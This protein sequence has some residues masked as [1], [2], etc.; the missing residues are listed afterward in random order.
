MSGS[1]SRILSRIGFYI[2]LAII[3]VYL[4]FPFY[5]VIRSAIV[6]NSVQ[7]TTPVVYWPDDPTWD[8]F[9]TVLTD[10]R[11]L[12]SLLNSAIVAGTVTLL[13]LAIGASS[14]YALGR[15][16]FR[17]RT[18]VLY[19]VLAMTMFPAVSV[20]GGLFTLVNEFHMYNSLRALVYSYLIFTLPFTVWVLTSF[21]R[22]MPKDLEEAAYVDGAT[23]F[24]TF[25]KVLLPLSAPGLVTTGLLAF[26]AAW[27]EFLYA[28][29]FLQTP[30][31]YTITLAIFNFS[32]QTGGGFEIPWGP[33]MAATV[34]V[35]IPL[36]VLTLIFQR[37]IIQGLTAG[38]VKG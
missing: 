18:P 33:M 25:W 2:L 11:F 9:R 15:F 7:F 36:I 28:L 21:F 8:N 16:Q 6:P 10:R 14:A 17:G 1:K 19:I 30:E 31:H 13:S 20:L 32:P 12:R 35:T 3:V 37:R 4:I 22:Q 29:S 38:A 24:Q 34:V 23:P 5:W 27:N 26:I